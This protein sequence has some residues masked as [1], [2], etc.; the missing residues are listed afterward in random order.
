VALPLAAGPAAAAEELAIVRRHLALALL[1][2][3]VG[4]AVRVGLRV[5]HLAEV[6]PHGVRGEGDGLGRAAAL[7]VG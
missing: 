6:D 7:L 4:D 2:L 5:A 3:L 1:V